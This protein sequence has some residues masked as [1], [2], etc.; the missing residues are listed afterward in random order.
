[1]AESI[2]GAKVR[3]ITEDNDIRVMARIIGA[4]DRMRLLHPEG[5]YDFV[6]REMRWTPEDAEKTL[7]GIDIRTL[8]LG[9]SL[10]AAMGVIKSEKVIEA[11]KEFGG[12]NALGMLAMR[13]LSTAS[14]LCMISI[15]GYD[16]KNFFEGGR[17]MERFW[18]EATNLNLAIHPVISPLYLFS[19]ILHGNGEG[20]DEKNIKEL[21]YLREAFN[22]ITNSDN[23]DSEVFLT[24]IAIAKEPLLKAHRLPLTEILSFGE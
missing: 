1:L 12:G 6:H 15:P 2:P 4:C 7:T 18:L 14:A 5:H 20:L 22:K 21:E 19:R 24:K 13:T 16:L 23:N 3:F 8:E 17:S 10:M 9:N 11:V